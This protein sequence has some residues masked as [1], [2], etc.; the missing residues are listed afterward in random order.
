MVRRKRPQRHEL[1]YWEWLE[2]RR[3]RRQMMALF[4]GVA[5]IMGALYAAS[6][7]MP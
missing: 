7:W 3:Q 2:R 1:G 6:L 4:V 5:I